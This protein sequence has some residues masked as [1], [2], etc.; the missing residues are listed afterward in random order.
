MQKTHPPSSR[1]RQSILETLSVTTLLCTAGSLAAQTAGTPSAA[2]AQKKPESPSN[3]EEVV[4]EAQG[5]VY[6]VD[7]LQ[8]PKFTEPLRDVPQ[9]I[10]VIPK[11]VFEDRG[12]FNLRD[13]LRNTPGISMQAGEGNTGGSGG[14]LLTI[15][16]ASASTDW[17]MDGVRDY[18]FYNRDP[19]NIEAV[20]VTKGPSS[21][22]AG[23]GVTGGAINLVSKMAHLGSDHGVNLTGGTDNLYRA[24]VDMNQQLGANA[25]L[26]VNGLY[27][28][29]DTPGRDQV[30]QERWGIAAS[31]GL[32]LDTD[33][34]FFLNYQHLDE[35]NLPDYGLPFVT[36]AAAGVGAPGEPPAVSFDNFY[37]DTA[38]DFEDIQHDSIT[39]I[40][41]HDFSDKVRLR[42]ITRYSRTH[43]ESI[44]TA[45]RFI[46]NTTNVQRNAQAYRLTQEA[47][48]N[49]TNLN[50]DFET[51]ALEHALV[52]GL[53]LSWERQLQAQATRNDIS[54]TNLL[55]PGTVVGGAV[56][57]G[58]LPAL[59]G[60]AE[61]HIDTIA[62]YL[63]DTVK[64]GKFFELNG[65]VRYDHVEARGRGYGGG[66]LVANSDELFSW[67]AGLVFKPVEHG[68][69]YFGYGTAQKA[70]LDAV[71]ALGVGIPVDPAPPAPLA[72]S[73]GSLDPEETR[74][75]ELGTKWDL[76]NERLSITA[77][78]FR[79]EKNNALVRDPASGNVL[80]LG[81]DQVVEGLELG[82]A[83]NLT[84]N[85]QVFAGFAWM[86]GRVTSNGTQPIGPLA[87][88]PETSGNLWT[89]YSLL[90]KKLQLGLGLQYMGDIHL[91]RTNS[92]VNNS[93]IAPQYLI[94]DAMVSY[95]FT[96]NFGLRL[97]IYNLADERYVDR[98]GGTVNQ[99]VPGP[100][101]SVALTATVKF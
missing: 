42:N 46:L 14:D 71:S 64:I 23:R 58:Q 21:A 39:A 92:V 43:R 97:N 10:T 6:K 56:G 85:W 2:P 89:T 48:V 52:T 17:F 72:Q 7:R 1:D 47:F 75:Y 13:V 20:E 66:A 8:S 49:Q 32:G 90:D 86:N 44:T 35:N 93:T 30:N 28:S 96:P 76:F 11:A 95:Q 74:A 94:W 57:A 16:G 80:G 41:E 5:E 3:L 24:T 53:E 22:N 69:I 37:G 78:L 4:I 27:H 87:N 73:L 26:R 15:R 18:G 54:R 88:I 29:A 63:F 12:A 62:F 65:G 9:T 31:L 84:Q 100:G 101:R 38:V 91:G 50:V 68:S 98:T 60:D 99:F 79:T 61:A 36:N 45:P 77:A 19:Y 82:L 70:S 33:T 40:L 51:G 59:P 25:A 67:K 83:G 34:R 55:A 81:G